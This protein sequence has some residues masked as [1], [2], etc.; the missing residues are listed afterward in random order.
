MVNLSI[1]DLRYNC[2][3]K[4][5]QVWFLVLSLVTIKSSGDP[6]PSNDTVSACKRNLMKIRLVDVLRVVIL[7]NFK[8]T[9]F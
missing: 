8:Q 9:K 1:M 2:H 3:H 6:I 5:L 4:H 7:L